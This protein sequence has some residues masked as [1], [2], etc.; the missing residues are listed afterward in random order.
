MKPRLDGKGGERGEQ[1][2]ELK[3]LQSPARESS[4]YLEGVVNPQKT[5]RRIVILA[6][7][8]ANEKRGWKDARDGGRRPLGLGLQ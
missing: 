3:A 4:F 2:S 5:G 6:I 7:E 1:K 8:E